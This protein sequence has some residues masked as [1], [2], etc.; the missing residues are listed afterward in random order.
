MAPLFGHRNDHMNGRAED[1]GLKAEVD[2]L[3]ALPMAQLATEVMLRGFGPG[4]HTHDPDAVTFGGGDGGSGPTVG[5]IANTYLHLY[6]DRPIDGR[7]RERLLSLIAE[8]FQA[9]EHASLVRPQLHTNAGS[10]HIVDYAVTRLGLS[11]M[12]EGTVARILA[13]A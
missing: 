9:L 4:Q 6:L 1:S 3:D 8:G 7:L 12:Q 10:A 2:R 13:R 5:G 11:A